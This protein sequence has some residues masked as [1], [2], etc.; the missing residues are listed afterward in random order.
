MI[1]KKQ[2]V[3]NLFTGLNF[4][5]GL[6][7]IIVVTGFHNQETLISWISKSPIVLGAWMI[8]WSVNM[9][10]MDGLTARLMNAS[11]EFGAE[12]DS[13][14]DLLTFGVAPGFLVFYFVKQKNYDWFVQNQP[15]MFVA[16]FVYAIC[17]AMRLARFNTNESAP[18][19]KVYFT[20]LPSTV[21]G[22][23]TALSVILFDRYE[24][25]DL[26]SHYIS[27]LPIMLIFLGVMM[28]S[29]LLFPK[30]MRRKK[31]W[32]NFFQLVFAVCGYVC[33]FAMIFPEFM[34]FIVMVYVLIGFCYGMIYRPQ[35]IQKYNQEEG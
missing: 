17:T 9:D 20:G 33:G 25:I 2:I 34:F 29:P 11:S 7:V 16:L 26:N 24:I 12:F 3:P 28:V 14:A 5:L 19:F 15:L 22:G 31:R 30:L 4:I 13:L 23:L 1:V 27:I 35:I 21:A 10:K 6:C 18:L 32:M 8:L